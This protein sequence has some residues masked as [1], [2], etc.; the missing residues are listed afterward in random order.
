MFPG[1]F[2]VPLDLA[3]KVRIEDMR[4]T[5]PSLKAGFLVFLLLSS[6]AASQDDKTEKEFV[7]VYHPELTIRR[8]AGP[9]KL[10]GVL[11]DEGWKGAAKA[12][13]FAEHNPGDQTQPAVN[14]EVLITYD[15]KNLYV[16]WIC[17]DDPDEVRASFCERDRIFQDDYVILMIDPYGEATYAYEIASNPLGIPGDLLFSSAHGE[18]I[19]FSMIFETMGKITE[20]GW[21]VEMEI[22]FRSLR[23]PSKEDQV[24][25][26]DFWRNRPREVRYQYSWAAYNRDIDCWPCNWGTIDG[27]SGIDPGKGL[28]LIPT[29]DGFQTGSV[30]YKCEIQN[31]DNEGEFGLWVKYDFTSKKYARV[32][33][34]HE[35]SQD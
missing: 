26:V 31:N 3:V 22:P 19:S 23:F 7:P 5:A 10:D 11:D 24:W 25:R 6:P 13:N 35:I 15:D 28:E 18:D 17:Y 1:I 2:P 9:I 30:D 21:V 29:V 34:N 20:F 4:I 14:T 16:A 8:A 27:I 32:T 12:D 33:I